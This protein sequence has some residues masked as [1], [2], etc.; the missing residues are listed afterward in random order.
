MPEPT[1]PKPSGLWARLLHTNEAGEPALEEAAA[2]AEPT[3]AAADDEAPSADGVA[4]P[5]L[6]VPPFPLNLDLSKP[7]TETAPAADVDAE[8]D[9]SAVEL[10]PVE[11]E[12]P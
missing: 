7:E 10:K 12:A 2:P 11:P 5:D 1:A 6:Q 9:E 4:G 3:T 8:R